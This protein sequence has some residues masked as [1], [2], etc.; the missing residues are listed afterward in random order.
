MTDVFAIRRKSPG[1]REP[2]FQ[3]NLGG[4]GCRGMRPPGTSCLSSHLKGRSLLAQRGSWLKKALSGFDQ[5]LGFDPNTR[6]IR[7]PSPS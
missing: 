1:D 2:P 4:E 5:A 6:W 7:G 3:V